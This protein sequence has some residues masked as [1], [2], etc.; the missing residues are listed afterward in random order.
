MGTAGDL[1]ADG[2]ADFVVNADKSYV[3]FGK[4]DGLD[5]VDLATLTPDQGF[6]VS[7][8][9]LPGDEGGP[10]G[11]ATGDFNGDGIDDVIF[12]APFA[13]TKAGADA[14]QAYVVFGAATGLGAIDVTTMPAA[15]GFQISGA[16]AGDSA[17]TVATSRR[18]FQRRWRR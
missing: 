15:Q 4:A 12:G 5:S 3:I 10:G 2:I 9:A 17:G 18:R 7:R 1:N 6:V 8:I 13:D 16:A 11:G 14:G